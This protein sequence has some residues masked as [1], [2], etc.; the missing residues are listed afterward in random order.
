[1]GG[2]NAALVRDPTSCCV[3]LASVGA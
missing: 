3:T 1:M 2:G